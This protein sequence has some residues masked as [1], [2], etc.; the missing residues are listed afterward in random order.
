[1][2]LL[3]AASRAVELATT[4]V[5]TREH[6]TKRLKILVLGGTRYVG[7]AIVKLS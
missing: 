5:T 3:P 1:M 6:D 2:A 7:P 4:P